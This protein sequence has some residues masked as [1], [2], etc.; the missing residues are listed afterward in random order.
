MQMRLEKSVG[1]IRREDFY[2]EDGA[3]NEKLP[4]PIWLLVRDVADIS[5][6]WERELNKVAQERGEGGP[7]KRERNETR[8]HN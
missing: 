8:L 5:E 6:E 7:E 2:L 4:W 3:Q 1:K